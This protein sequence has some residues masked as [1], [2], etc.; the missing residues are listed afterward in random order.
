MARL[1]YLDERL[2]ASALLS[3]LYVVELMLVVA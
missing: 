2:V 1:E 3:K